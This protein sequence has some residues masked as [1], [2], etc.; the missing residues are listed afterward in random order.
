MQLSMVCWNGVW[1]G[2][3]RRAWNRPAPEVSDPQK[4]LR[5]LST[6]LNVLQ[7]IRDVFWSRVSEV[8]EGDVMYGRLELYS[9]CIV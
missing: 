2:C 6:H 4:V 3:D 9:E 1:R 5:T 7:K 8:E